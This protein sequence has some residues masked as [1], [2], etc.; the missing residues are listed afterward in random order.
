MAYEKLDK[1]EEHR[2]RMAELT[3]K[4]IEA[5]MKR[6]LAAAEMA[7]ASK[8]LEDLRFI[9]NK[10]AGDVE[11]YA[12]TLSLFARSTVLDEY[13]IPA[14]FSDSM[15]ANMFPD[16]A[17]AKRT[18]PGPVAPAPDPAPTTDPKAAPQGGQAG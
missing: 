1:S 3:G 9:H 8:A 18:P 2:K 16:V 17:K 11:S 12:S 5:K 6:D 7:E 14:S 13:G 15:V 4:A 10:L